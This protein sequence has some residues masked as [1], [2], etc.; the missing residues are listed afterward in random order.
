VR[1]NGVSNFDIL[2][3]EA[4]CGPCE[5]NLEKVKKIYADEIKFLEDQGC[6]QDISCKCCDDEG[7]GGYFQANQG[8][9]SQKKTGSIVLC[10]GANDDEYS[11]TITFYHELI[12]AL[13]NCNKRERGCKVSVCKEI[14]SY[15]NSN[16]AYITDPVLKKYCVKK[17]V[18]F[19]SKS[20]CKG[21]K[22]GIIESLFE[23]SYEECSKAPSF[24]K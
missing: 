5:E 3:L 6:S 16:C 10:C 4:D 8:R 14:Q 19:S 23:K 9:F 22:E 21:E 11:A 7:V 24:K 2:G 12:H 15:A 20:H 1:N 13:Q 18:K 17:G